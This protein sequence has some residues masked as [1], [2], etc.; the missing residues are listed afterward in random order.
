MTVLGGGELRLLRDSI[1]SS[2]TFFSE[3]HWEFSSKKDRQVP[4]E[5]LP[6]EAIPTGR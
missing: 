5:A 4:T 1:A 6:G 3:I 2:L